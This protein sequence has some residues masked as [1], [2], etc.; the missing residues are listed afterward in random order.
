M[1]A[2][3]QRATILKLLRTAEALANDIPEPTLAYLVGVAIDECQ[4]KM[5]A[6]TPRGSHAKRL[7]AITGLRRARP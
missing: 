3:D 6:A 1:S 7:R 5:I 2:D 4:A